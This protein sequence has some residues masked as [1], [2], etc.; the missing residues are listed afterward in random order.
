MPGSGKS[1]WAATQ[2]C[3]VVSLDAVRTL[4]APPSVVLAAAEREVTDRLRGG[5]DVVVDGCSFD[6]RRR[7][8]WL[9]IA[10]GE[11][12]EAVA[13]VMGTDPVL[14]Q[15]RN[16]AR[17]SVGAGVPPQVMGRYRRQWP[18]VRRA[19]MSEGWDRV[20]VV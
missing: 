2:G 5:W 15:R 13:V 11:G 7:A 18:Y 3:P 10:R 17:R 19:V 16:A 14:A 20:E 6:P 8:R 12:A 4:G 1:T 9:G